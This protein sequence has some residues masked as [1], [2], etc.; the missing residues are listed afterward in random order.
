MSVRRMRPNS[1]QLAVM[2]KVDRKTL[3]A[4][5][6]LG[7]GHAGTHDTLRPDH[8]RVDC[9]GPERTAKIGERA[10]RIDERTKDHVA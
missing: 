1:A 2:R 10:T 7:G 9:K 8:L 6:E 4:N 5:L 3:T